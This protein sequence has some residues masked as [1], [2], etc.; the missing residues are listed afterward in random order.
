[1]AILDET[2]SGLDVDALRV[3][4]E[5]VNTCREQDN[6]LG[7]L[8]ITHYTRILRYI[9]PDFV[10]VFYD[11]RIVESG[12]PEL[13]DQLGGVLRIRTG[14]RALHR[15]LVRLA[16]PPGDP[17]PPLT[18]RPLRE[19]ELA[20][21][22]LPD[23][24]AA[25]CATTGPWSTS[26][27][28][29]T[30]Q[31]PASVLD[32]ERAFYETSNAGV[33]R[34][35]HQLAEEATDRLRGGPGRPSPRFVGAPADDLVFTK[36]ATE[37]LN[38]GRLRA[39]RTRPPSAARRGGPDPVDPRFGSSRATRS[40]SPRWSTTRTSCRGRSSRADR[41]HAAVDR[42]DRRGPPRPRPTSTGS[43]TRR[44]KVVVT[45]AP[46][47]QRAGHPQPRAGSVMDRAHDVGA[48]GASTPASRCRT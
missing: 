7:I 48:L 25:R 47:Q 9:K 46:R 27:Q 2:D 34:G 19:A 20:I 44:L 23:P 41:G 1:M 17:E 18:R 29:A 3:V 12:G 11:G 31:K 38:L 39:S 28:A 13:A 42:P 35:A 21:R 4:S 5:G 22:G 26:T 16:R 43:S 6:D 37:S 33:H 10:H 32:A 40:W 8:L 30:S 45:R 15:P 14:L 36:N 24:R